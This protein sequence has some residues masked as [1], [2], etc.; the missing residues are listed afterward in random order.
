MGDAQRPGA[1][2]GLCAQC[3]HR[4]ELTSAR[5]SVFHRCA[6]AEEDE[7]FPRY[8][9]LPVRR[10]PGYEPVADEADPP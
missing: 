7:R 1:A 6:R 8:P 4:R 5:G 9:P 3:R 2:I 10:C